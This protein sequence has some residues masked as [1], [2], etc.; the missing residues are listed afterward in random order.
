MLKEYDLIVPSI[1]GFGFGSLPQKGYV[2]NA[3]T[4]KIWH[5]LMTEVLGYQRYVA[6]GGDMGRGV[7]SYIAANHPHELEG[8]FLTD[9][10]FAV[11][12]VATPDEKLSPEW[13][14][15]KRLQQNG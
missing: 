6:T 12:I 2:N 1:H 4:V 11:D 13:L 5:K 15:L 14:H 9:I 10:G 7:L 3:D 8:L